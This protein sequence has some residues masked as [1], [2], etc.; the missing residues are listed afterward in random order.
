MV[1]CYCRWYNRMSRIKST[2]SAER[3]LLNVCSL[4]LRFSDDHR[5]E[6]KRK[7]NDFSTVDTNVRIKRNK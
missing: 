3:V 2:E 7:M 6:A 5:R 4:L 1:S